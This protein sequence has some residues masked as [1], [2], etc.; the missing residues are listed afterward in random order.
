MIRCDE[1]DAQTTNQENEYGEFICGNCEQNKAERDW[2]RYCEAFHDGGSAQFVTL[3]QRQIEA[4]R[5][6]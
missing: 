4:R 5:F 3:Q 2:E 1:C 6:K